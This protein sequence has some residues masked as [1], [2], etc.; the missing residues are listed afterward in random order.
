MLLEPGSSLSHRGA[1]VA[2]TASVPLYWVGP[3]GTRC[4]AYDAAAQLRMDRLARQVRMVTVPEAARA[5]AQFMLSRRFGI[6]SH[7]RHSVDVVRGKEGRAVRQ[8]YA[9]LAEQHGVEWLARRYDQPWQETSAINRAI[10]VATSCLYGLTEVAITLAG[11]SPHLAA[12]HRS[13]QRAFVYDVADMEKLAT[14]VPLAFRAVAHGGEHGEWMVRPWC[15]EMF[16]EG[17]LLPRLIRHT[18]EI[19]DASDVEA[20][21]PSGGG[22]PV[23]SARMAGRRRGSSRT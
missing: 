15:A 21:T 11:Y 20:K 14:V 19:I 18:E 4:L 5:A 8:A 2:A 3:G 6:T 10:S 22:R 12:I 23:V 13:H 16:R 17:W 1:R 9:D 7:P